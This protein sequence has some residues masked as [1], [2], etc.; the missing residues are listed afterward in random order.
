MYYR[1]IFLVASLVAA[2]GACSATDENRTTTDDVVKADNTAIN[3]R[4]QSEAKLTPM[5]QGT[6]E[7]DRM[8]TQSI[9][10]AVVENASLSMN[11]KNVKVISIDGVVTLRGPVENATEKQTIVDAARA[12]AGVT[13]VVDELE[14]VTPAGG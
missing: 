8:L 9:R 13:R 11:A 6:S 1:K 7:A 3:Q 14:V 2:I 5:D 12:I 10:Q 4:D